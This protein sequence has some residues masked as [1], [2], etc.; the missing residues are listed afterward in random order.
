MTR[1]ASIVAACVMVVAIALLVS[2]G[3]EKLLPLILSHPF[4]KWLPHSMGWMSAVV[5]GIAVSWRNRDPKPQDEGR[6]TPL[7]PRSQRPL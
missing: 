7:P 3:A 6:L 2:W 4:P 5:I 1:L